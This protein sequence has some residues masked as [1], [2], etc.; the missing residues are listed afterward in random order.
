[1]AHIEKVPQRPGFSWRYRRIDEPAKEYDFHFH[2]DVF[3]L[4]IHRHFTGTL[5]IG[6]H[7][8]EVT[9]NQMLLIAPGVPHSIHSTSVESNCETHVI[10]FKREWIANLMF[11]CTELRKL[12]PL[13][14]AANKGV[15]FSERTAQQVVDLLQE[16]M[17]VPAMEQLSRFIHILSL[18]A[19]DEAAKTLMTHSYLSISEHEQQERE[20]VASV[21][22]YLE[23]HFA[24]KVTLADLANYLSLSESAVTRL[25]QKHFKEPFSQRLMKLRINHAADLLQST[26]LPIG[27]V[28]ER[29]GYR[30]QALFN[31]H[32]K[33]YKGLTP[34]DYRQHYQQRIQP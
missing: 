29:V 15:V 19:H 10:W 6:H 16:L 14:K 9:H 18:V 26:E 22:A 30:N 12:D 4:V 5:H 23:Q 7:E 24:N 1:M 27:I 3:E 2:D 20:R 34:R 8:L 11:Y 33:T 25:F 13:L 17:K 31:R 21:N 28:F 32:F